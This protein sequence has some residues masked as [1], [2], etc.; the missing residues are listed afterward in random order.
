MCRKKGIKI[1][2]VTSAHKRY[3]MRIFK[4]QCISLAEY[5]YD[6]TLLVN[7][8]GGDEVVDDVKIIST[9]FNAQNR[10]ERMLGSRKIIREK[11]FAINAD[12]YHLHD[13]ELLPLAGELKRMGKKVVFDFHEDSSKQILYK[14]WIPVVLRPI[15]AKVY[16]RYERIKAKR[17][18]A[19]I[20]VTPSF[21]DRLKKINKNTVMVTNYPIVHEK[22]AR[23]KSDFR[24]QICFAGGILDQWNHENIIKSLEEI[25]NVEYA[26]AGNGPSI[27]MERIEALD[28][29]SKVKFH[30]RISHSEVQD[31][32]F[33]S[34]AGMT[35][36]SNK[37]QV[38]DE[39]TLG[40]TKIFEF[41][42]AGIPVICSSNK[43]WAEIV[44]RYNCGIAINPD[45]I[46][47]I[48]DAIKLLMNNL[49]VVER[50]GANGRLAVENEYNWMSQVQELLDC[51][52][53]IFSS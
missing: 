52:S 47:E 14:H 34:L 3:D 37:S 2:H 25:D 39:G 40:N 44:D 26:L 27:Y 28:G 15:V 12:L 42:E 38:G 22:R 19:L 48:V 5:G 13:P 10:F 46:S 11:A 32:Y 4:K 51:Y 18:D 53:K 41:M 36:L 7:D 17:F 33:E 20:T 43:L 21:V 9:Q 8:I 49:D 31:I 1:C 35:L 16:E 29:W 23:S 45:S 6:V 30:G 24:R 50:M